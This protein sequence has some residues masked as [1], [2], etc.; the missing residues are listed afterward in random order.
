M[1]QQDIETKVKDLL[2]KMTLAEKIGQMTQPE[3]NSVRP[4]DVAA[5]ALG[6]VLSGG[7]GNP[8]PNTPA[9]WADMVR[10]FQDEALSSRLGIPLLYGVDAVHG[11]NNVRGATIFPHLVSLGAAGDPDLARRVARATAVE[12]AAT[13]VRWDFAPMVAVVQDVRWGRAFEAFGDETALVSELGAAYVRGLQEDDGRPPTADGRQTEGGGQRSA[14]GGL[15]IPTA[16]L[17]TPKHYIGDGATLWGTS[18]MEMLDVK[19]SI[20]QGDVREDEAALRRKYLPPYVAALEAGALCVMASFSSWQG[21]KMHA[22]HHL[23]TE[24]LKDELGFRG[25]VVSDW[26]AVDQIDPDFGVAVA[27]AVNAGIDMVMV[28]Y[29]YPRF[30]A[31]LTAAVERGD[32]A[33]SRID[34]AVARILR[35]KFALGL[36]ER[37]HTD[38]ALLARV[39]C[40]DHRA[41]AREAVRRSVVLLRNKGGALPRR[42]PGLVLLAGEAGDDIGLQCGGWTIKWQGVSGRAATEGTTILEGLQQTAPPGS[43]IEFNRFGRFDH[44]TDAAGAPLTADLGLV[45]LHEPPY[46]EG[47]GDRADLCLSADDVALIERVK[48]RSRQVAVLLVTGRPLII[49]DALPLAD[50]WLAVWWPGSEGAGVGDVVFGHHPFTGRLPTHWPRSMAQLPLDTLLADPAGPLFP[51]G[52]GLTE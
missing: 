17:A 38:P 23:L 8:T 46:A 36:F 44:V 48:A 41:L 19:F 29:D 3:K 7:G 14:V 18:R 21:V 24:V 45:V 32:V 25:F 43:R 4:G 40:P 30:M 5:L 47:L 28:P 6:S 10:A 33:Q 2:A 11:H 1:N 16:V 22:H 34:D 49:T 20:D 9:A 52:F 37:P 13:G 51:G 31:T 26:M 27:R 50:A 39:G 35:V 42:A 15:S 12:C